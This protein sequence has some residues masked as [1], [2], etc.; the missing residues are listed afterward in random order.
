MPAENI[1]IWPGW[2]KLYV[3]ISSKMCFSAWS[4]GCG[5]N[6]CAQHAASM[7]PYWNPSTGLHL[8]PKSHNGPVSTSACPSCDPLTPPPLR[9]PP[10]LSV[11]AWTPTAPQRLAKGHFCS[12]WPTLALQDPFWEEREYAR[13]ISS[14]SYYEYIFFILHVYLFNLSNGNNWYLGKWLPCWER[15]EE[16]DTAV[17]CLLHMKLQ[18]EN[19]LA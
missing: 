5:R 12:S 15:E 9:P 19:S 16:V 17:T 3:L 6:R 2:N 11:S 13:T 7:C 18:P 1:S 4:S 8:A 10:H 14:Y